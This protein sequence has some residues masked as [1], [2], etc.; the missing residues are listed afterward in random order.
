MNREIYYRDYRPSDEHQISGLF[1]QVFARRMSYAFWKWRYRDNPNGRGIIRLA[2]DGERLV[3]HMALTPMLVK[4]RNA[5]YR[6][7]LPTTAMTHPEYGGQGIF[8]RLLVDVYQYATEN[9]FTFAY[10]FFNQNPVYVCEKLGY[11]DIVRVSTME[12][13]LTGRPGQHLGGKNIRQI[14]NFDERFDLFW[15]RV[16]SDYA[17]IVSRDSRFLNWRFSRYQE[18]KYDTFVCTVANGEISGYIVFKVYREGNIV[19]GHVVDL[20]AIHDEAV[21]KSLICKAYH[22]FWQRGVMNISGWF[23]Q[24]SIC[25]PVLTAEGF[26][27]HQGSTYFGA[28]LLNERDKEHLEVEKSARWHLTMADSDVF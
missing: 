24:D 25:I 19:R 27:W 14:N 3:G 17:I 12:K 7:V 6:A 22:Y 23:P 11:R 9:G 28:K 20:L 16:K 1:Q 13:K 8:T 18:V 21:I 4:F 5:V 10:G 15:N 2:F 26:T